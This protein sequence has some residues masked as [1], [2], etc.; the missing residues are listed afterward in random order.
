MIYRSINLNTAPHPSTLPPCWTTHRSAPAEVCWNTSAYVHVRE[1]AAP[2]SLAVLDD[3]GISVETCW[4]ISGIYRRVGRRGRVSHA[5]PTIPP[6][7]CASYWL[8]RHLQSLLGGQPPALSQ[9]L[10]TARPAPPSQHSRARGPARHRTQLPSP[11]R[12]SAQGPCTGTP[13]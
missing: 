11:S 8:T 3:V 2:E 1:A 4:N 5:S 13:A 10:P 6:K 9:T 7:P 12:H